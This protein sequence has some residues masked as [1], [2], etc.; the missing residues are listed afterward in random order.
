MSYQALSIGFQCQPH[1]QWYRQLW[2]RIFSVLESW[3]LKPFSLKHQ[4]SFF[5]VCPDLGGNVSHRITFCWKTPLKWIGIIIILSLILVWGWKFALL[6]LRFELTAFLILGSTNCNWSFFTCFTQL[7]FLWL[8][9][10][11]CMPWE[12]SQ[13]ITIRPFSNMGKQFWLF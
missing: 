2:L 12:L 3:C 7:T 9:V 8:L 6:G 4:F 11:P 10:P 13:C 5:T 1:F